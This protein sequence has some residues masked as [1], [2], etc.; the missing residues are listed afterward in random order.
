MIY[1]IYSNGG[2]RKVRGGFL[3][4][5]DNLSIKYQNLNDF[6]TKATLK[7]FVSLGKNTTC[8]LYYGYNKIFQWKKARTRD[9]SKE[10]SQD[11]PEKVKE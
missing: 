8:L 10:E 5:K 11:D 2:Y 1:D 6:K 9:Q 7:S 4:K 3:A